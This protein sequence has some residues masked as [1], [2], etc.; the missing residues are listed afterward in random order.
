MDFDYAKF[1]YLYYVPY[2]LYWKW[3][4]TLV[5]LILFFK[6]GNQIWEMQRRKKQKNY[7]MKYRQDQRLKIL[8][9]LADHPAPEKFLSQEI[10]AASV[11]DLSLKAKSGKW[12]V[13]SIIL[14]YI[15][16]AASVHE[17]LNC[18][19][20]ILF[21]FAIERARLLDSRGVKDGP[22]FGVPISIK[23]SFDI[24]G[25]PTSIGAIKWAG[26][27]RERNSNIY[28]LLIDA[29]AVPFCKTNVPQTMMS[30]ECRCISHI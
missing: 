14:T 8:N 24:A 30:F 3:G 20:E 22:L 11:E 2:S 17:E 19:T 7:A 29:G 28:D 4:I 27:K 25:I 26:Q 13:E 12:S 1:I 18:I 6:I 21:D 9:F 5:T 10:L 23:D 16:K 15:H